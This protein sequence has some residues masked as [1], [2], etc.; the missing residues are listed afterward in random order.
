MYK[1]DNKKKQELDFLIELPD[2]DI[3]T[4]NIQEIGKSQE[5]RLITKKVLV[6]FELE[7]NQAW[8]L[9]QLAKRITFTHFQEL[10]DP[11]DKDEPFVMR[12]AIYQLQDA[13]KEAGYAPR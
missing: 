12:S 9:A 10:S 7:D 4:S 5:D 13:L 3:D 6:A 1:I 8:E 2:L 11:T